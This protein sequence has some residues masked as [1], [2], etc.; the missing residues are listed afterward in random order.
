[1]NNLT[2]AQC[3]ALIGNI[4]LTAAYFDF[5]LRAKQQ[6]DLPFIMYNRQALAANLGGEVVMADTLEALRNLGLIEFDFTRFSVEIWKP[7][8]KQAN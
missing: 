3:M 1:M 6:P 4:T 8:N 2:E 7:Q 5:R